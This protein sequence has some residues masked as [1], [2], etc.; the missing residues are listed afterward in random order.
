VYRAKKTT[1]K[2]P[3]RVPSPYFFFITQ[4]GIL[5]SLGHQTSEPISIRLMLFCSILLMTTTVLK[6]QQF[7]FDEMKNDDEKART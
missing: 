3:K 2:Q 7:L 1:G 5:V 4:P 6:T